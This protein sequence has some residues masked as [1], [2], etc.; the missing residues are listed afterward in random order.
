MVYQVTG[1]FFYFALVKQRA[2]S[3]IEWLIMLTKYFLRRLL[4]NSPEL[5]DLVLEVYRNMNLQTKIGNTSS[6][7][8][9]KNLFL[10]CL[11]FVLLLLFFAIPE[12]YFH[13]PGLLRN[14]VKIRCSSNVHIFFEKEDIIICIKLNNFNS[15]TIFITSFLISFSYRVCFFFRSVTTIFHCYSYYFIWYYM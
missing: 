5:E 1:F 8:K 13:I 12:Y 7:E 15:L 6:K 14:N 11:G 4:T 9:W 3:N 2:L 10:F